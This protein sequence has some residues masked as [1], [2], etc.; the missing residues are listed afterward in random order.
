MDKSKEQPGNQTPNTPSVS[1]SELAALT[2]DELKGK[3]R[4]RHSRHRVRCAS[5]NS[6]TLKRTPPVEGHD[7][8]ARSA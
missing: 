7:E 6:A 4:S 3:E 8:H 5:A 2:V 1:D